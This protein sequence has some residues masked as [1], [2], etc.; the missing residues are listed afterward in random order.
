MNLTLIRHVPPILMLLPGG[1]LSDAT[2]VE[3]YGESGCG[4]EIHLE[5]LARPEPARVPADSHV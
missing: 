5:L 1:M 3:L 2:D 4:E